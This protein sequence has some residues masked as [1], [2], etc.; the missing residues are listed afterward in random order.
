MLRGEKSVFI[1]NWFDKGVIF[2]LDL[3]KKNCHFYS[4][5]EISEL[6]AVD[7]SPR[8][9]EWVIN[10]ISPKWL[11]LFRTNCYRSLKCEIPK[12]CIG[13][14]EL[15]N[16]K[17]NNFSIRKILIKKFSC[18]PKA[19]YKWKLNYHFLS[20]IKIWAVINTFL[21]PNKMK[22][23]H[24]KNLHMY[25]PCNSLLSKF[26]LD[27]SSQ[28]IFCYSNLETMSHVFFECDYAKDV[29]KHMS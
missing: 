28:C 25:Y 10:S 14:L 1:Q 13:G 22:D 8:V 16:I 9:Y 3:L 20:T 4:Y 7:A 21:L 23:L 5:S 29:W 11:H 12:K 26:K 2:V 6:F 15:C 24:Y 19:F 18:H 27:I 17:C